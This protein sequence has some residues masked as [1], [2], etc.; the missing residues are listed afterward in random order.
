MTEKQAVSIV[1]HLETVDISLLY[2]NCTKCHTKSLD[3]YSLKEVV[4]RTASIGRDM[5]LV[6]WHGREDAELR[7]QVFV[8]R[9]NG[10][11]VAASVA[12]VWCRPNSYNGAIVKVIL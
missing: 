9:H 3:A 11:D 2:S 12:V 5:S 4:A 8:N 7:V 6:V 1:D 10:R